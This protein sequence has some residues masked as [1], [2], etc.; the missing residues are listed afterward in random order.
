MKLSRR[1][2]PILIVLLLSGCASTPKP[3]TA[4]L[5][6]LYCDNFL[7]Y[8]MCAQDI[9][10]DG[11][12]ELVY[13]SDTNEI[14][15]LREGAE[16]SVPENLTLH[17]CF[18]FMNDEIVHNTSQ[19][20]TISDDTNYLARTDLKSALMFS[21]MSYMPR[22]MRCNSRYPDKAVEPEPLEDE[23]DF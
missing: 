6:T 14:F 18:Q 11:V 2:Y 21:Y 9:D 20:F 1:L 5:S 7:I 13:F 12:V 3:T 23:F 22:V 4:V 10:A 8:D 17:R 19:L 15:L 16:D